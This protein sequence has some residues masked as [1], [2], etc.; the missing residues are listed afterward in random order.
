MDMHFSQIDTTTGAPTKIWVFEGSVP[1]GKPSM[2]V[3]HRFA[4]NTHMA[5]G[6][7]FRGTMR[8]A[9]P[10]PDGSVTTLGTISPH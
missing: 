1:G 2:S 5:L 9:A 7:A 6:F 10:G 4:D 8:L 3:M